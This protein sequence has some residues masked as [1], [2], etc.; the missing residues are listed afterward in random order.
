MRRIE[1]AARFLKE[2]WQALQDD[3]VFNGAAAVA[4]FVMLSIFPAAIFLI[5]LIPYLPIPNLHQAILDLLYQVIP[6]QSATLLEG[7]VVQV[8][9]QKEGGWLTFSF[10]LMIWAASGGF[11]AA[12]E[13][14]NIVYGVAERR[15]FWKV[16]AIAA[17]LLFLFFSLLIGALSLAI[18]G[19]VIQSRL[20]ALLGWSRPLLAF[21]AVLR[22]VILAAFLLLGLALM[23]H[24][25]PNVHRKF[26]LLSPGGFAG[27]GLIALAS[28]GFQFYIRH[29]SD[30][31]ATYGSLGAMIIL[32]L[33]L[34]LASVALL[35]GSEINAL[36][37]NR[38]TQKSSQK[39][40]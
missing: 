38:Y 1:T 6:D 4:F 2:L 34:Y 10:L 35:V 7:V 8:I 17:L 12:M 18:F 30:Y 28:L 36:T 31:S 26:R 24:W 22:W 32:M 21:F 33:W 29:F 20:A 13:Q 19:G 9:S 3:H 5:S 25:G 27:A 40:T 37:E 16:R 23:Y 39:T 15:P 11:F 14:M